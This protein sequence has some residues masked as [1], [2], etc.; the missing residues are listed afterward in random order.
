MGM[1]QGGPPTNIDWTGIAAIITAVTGLATAAGGLWIRK[2]R[3][4]KKKSKDQCE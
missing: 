3:K 2:R 1:P 4:R